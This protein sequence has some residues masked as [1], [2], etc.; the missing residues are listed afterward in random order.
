[1]DLVDKEVNHVRKEAKVK[2]QEKINWNIQKHKG[3]VSPENGTHKGVLVGDIE[4]GN[5]EKE[6]GGT[7]KSEAE[8]VVYAGIKVNK[9]EN[10]ILCLPP[11][12]TIYPKVDIEEFDTDMEKCVIKCVWQAKNEERKAEEK[13][14][15]EE[16]SDEPE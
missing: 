1:M 4:L 7:T 8:A 2:S 3:K 13:K 9:K 12:H 15:R 11:D 5:F 6:K 16:A 10:D 14:A